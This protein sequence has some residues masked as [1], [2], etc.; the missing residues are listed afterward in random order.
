MSRDISA[1]NHLSVARAFKP[2]VFVIIVIGILCATVSPAS[3]H[4]ALV[5]TNPAN[6]SVLDQSPP[7]IDVTFTQGARLSQGHIELFDSEGKRIVAASNT[8]APSNVLQVLPP[9]LKKGTYLV[10]WSVVSGDSHPIHGT[11]SFTVNAAPEKNFTTKP[12]IAKIIDGPR[13]FR[14]VQV[15]ATTLRFLIFVSIVLVIALVAMGT[16]LS[17][18]PFPRSL[19]VI[20]YLTLIVFSLASFLAIGVQ[21]VLVAPYSLSKVFEY[22]LWKEVLSTRFA[23]V[24][25]GRIGLC[26]ALFVSWRYFKER[27]QKICLIVLAITVAITP[28]L[29]GHASDGKYVLVAFVNDVLH[30]FAA[31]TWLGCLLLLPFMLRNYEECLPILKRFSRLAPACAIVIAL[32]GVFAWWRQIG[33]YNISTAT[34]FGQLINI[35]ILLFTATLAM[36]WFSR[37]YSK[38]LLYGGDQKESKSKLIRLMYIESA[39]L[40]VA[41]ALSSIAVNAIP[42]RIAYSAPVIRKLSAQ[43]VNIEITVEPAKA[44][45]VIIHVFVYEKNGLPKQIEDTNLAKSSIRAIWTNLEGKFK[46]INVP[47]RFEGLNHFSS[48]GATIPA[49]GKW[50]FSVEID[51]D[52]STKTKAETTINFR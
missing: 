9:K 49:P 37:Q 24:Q 4:A 15:I 29:I 39:L 5:S 7:T 18:R 33:S 8:D 3:A 14:E 19:N 32:T 48:A 1:S 6:E 10:T 38:K 16:Y 36:A 46:P 40:C 52:R 51:V 44:G 35:K 20:K 13:D 21:A 34:W 11:F 26:A 28:A 42:G 50:T 47:M 12:E 30:V 17:K 45:P 25:L 23:V 31:S 43:S 22:S 41:I 2:L 27:L